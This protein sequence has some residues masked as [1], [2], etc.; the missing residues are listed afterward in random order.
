MD[1]KRGGMV[2]LYGINVP[3]NLDKARELVVYASQMDPA[4]ML[5][6]TKEQQF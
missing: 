6:E 3:A 4:G 1:Y 2:Y 5:R